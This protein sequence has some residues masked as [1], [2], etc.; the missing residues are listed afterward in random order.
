[1]SLL[2]LVCYVDDFCKHRGFCGESLSGLRGFRRCQLRSRNSEMMLVVG[3]QRI[4]GLMAGMGL[5]TR[6][7]RCLQGTTRADERHRHV[8]N[9]L[10]G[11]FTAVALNETWLV[12]ITYIETHECWFYLAGV[13]C[14]AGYAPAASFGSRQSVYQPPV[15]GVAG[16]GGRANEYEE[17]RTLL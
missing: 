9:Q 8:E 15:F 7:R 3:R 5:K 12:D 11:V 1:M 13:L 2:E 14:P 10:K 4:A 17:C 16:T 6:C